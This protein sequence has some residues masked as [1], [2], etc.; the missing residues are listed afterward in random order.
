MGGGFLSKYFLFIWRIRLNDNKAF[1]RASK[2]VQAL[3]YTVADSFRANLG[4]YLPRGLFSYKRT[5]GGIHLS[6]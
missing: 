3:Q 6:S 2:Y 4:K 5:Q 1:D